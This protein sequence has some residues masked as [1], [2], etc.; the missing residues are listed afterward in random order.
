[1]TITT[2]NVVDRVRAI[3]GDKSKVV[4]FD[5]DIFRWI[6]DAQMRVVRATETNLTDFVTTS[7]ASIWQY[8][9]TPNGFLGIRNVKYNG[10]D[11]PPITREKLNLLDPYW[12]QS[13]GTKIGTPSFY[14]TQGTGLNLYVTPD[15]SGLTITATYVPRPPVVANGVDPLV[16]ADSMLESIVQLCLEQAKTWDEDWAGAAY[17]QKAAKDRMAEDTYDEQVSQ[18]ESYPSIRSVPGDNW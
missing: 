18:L 4:Y 16:V 12:M 13:P 17:F 8:P 11:I 7:G 14:W 15:T 1:V 9:V 10:V 6:N 2:Q 3:T 5:M